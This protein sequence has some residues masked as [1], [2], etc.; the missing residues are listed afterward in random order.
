M[1]GKKRE[2]RAERIYEEIMFKISPNLMR[3]IHLHIQEVQ[4]TP[5]RANLK[6]STNM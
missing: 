3:N 6:K 2:K 4:Q 1:R 5:N